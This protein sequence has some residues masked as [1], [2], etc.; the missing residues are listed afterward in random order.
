[1]CIPMTWAAVL[2]ALERKNLVAALDRN[3]TLVMNYRLLW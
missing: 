1:M 3:K 2:K